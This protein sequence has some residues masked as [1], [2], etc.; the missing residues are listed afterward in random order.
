MKVG[1][2]IRIKYYE[3]KGETTPWY[4]GVLV[5]SAE[6]SGISLDMMWCAETE[7]LHV[8]KRS[9]DLIELLCETG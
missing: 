3:D 4:H 1:D 6:E 5:E 8:I 7:S 2:L 9:K